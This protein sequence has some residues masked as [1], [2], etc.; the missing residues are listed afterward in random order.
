MISFDDYLETFIKFGPYQVKMFFIVSLIDFMDGMETAFLGIFL[1]ILASEWSLTINEIIG[2]GTA[3]YFGKLSGN[4]FCA[5][6]AD[7]IGRKNSF[8]IGIFVTF[9]TFILNS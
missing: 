4:I 3:F 1:S 9:L 2:L 5:L 6:F 8:I 7:K